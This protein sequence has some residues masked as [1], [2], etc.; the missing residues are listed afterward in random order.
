MSYIAEAHAEWHFV[1]GKF[2]SCPLDCG[3]NEPYVWACEG[4]G[5]E[6]VE[7]PSDPGKVYR[8]CTDEATCDMIISEKAAERR[9]AEAEREAEAA[10]VGGDPWDPPF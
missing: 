8:A 3:V 5:G 7:Y 4:C 10:L 2:A 9:A 1:H 6:M